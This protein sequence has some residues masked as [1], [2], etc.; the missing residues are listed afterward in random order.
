MPDLIEF[1]ENVITYFSSK[2]SENTDGDEVESP[3]DNPINKFGLGKFKTDKKLLTTK[4][5]EEMTIPIV[6]TKIMMDSI[7]SVYNR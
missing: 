1:V 2:K 5:K 3:C 6:K 4:M 7:K